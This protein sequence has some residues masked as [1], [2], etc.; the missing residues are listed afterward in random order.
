MQSQVNST[1]TEESLT[2]H[3]IKS[4]LDFINPCMIC[5]ADI[6]VIPVEMK[7][8]NCLRD[9]KCLYRVCMDCCREYL[10]LN[11][12]KI[13]RIA[14]FEDGRS[15]STVKC[16]T[17]PNRVNLELINSFMAYRIDWFLINI[18]DKYHPKNFNCDRCNDF[19]GSQKDILHHYKN[20][21]SKRVVKCNWCDFLYKSDEL[22][23]HLL[24]CRNAPRCY[25]CKN[26]MIDSSHQGECP[27][28][29]LR[30]G[31]CNEGIFSKD[32]QEHI[33]RHSSEIDI[34]YE[35]VISNSNQPGVDTGSMVISPEGEIQVF[36]VGGI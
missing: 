8:F 24:N 20:T 1:S 14:H 6:P 31:Y 29:V 35:K 16:L 28:R 33:Q 4:L 26:V 22:T 3:P 36:V 7:C 15:D 18:I 5:H 12:P 30:C 19:K 21:C 32:F 34:R 27:Q 11:K 25:Y 17:C 10:K 23:S 2:S 9:G 13:R